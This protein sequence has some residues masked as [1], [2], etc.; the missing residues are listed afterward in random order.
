[1]ASKIKTVKVVLKKMRKV[2]GNKYKAQAEKLQRL[3]EEA[4]QQNKILRALKTQEFIPGFSF[5]PIL[6]T[7]SYKLCHAFAYPD[8]VEGMF[9][10]IEARTG[11]LD[12]IV[13][14]GAQMWVM[15]HLTVQI[16]PAMIDEAEEFAKLHGEPFNR[17][18]WE[19]IIEKYD[20]FLPIKIRITPEGMPIR[21][22][23]AIVTV[24]CTDKKVQWLT[25]YI[26][27]ALLRGIWYPTTIASLDYSIKHHLRE[28]YE[29]TGAD[30]AMLSFSLHDFG[31]RGVTCGE[32]AQIGGAAHLVNFMGSDTIE[33]IRA[34]NFFYHEKMSGFSVP[35]TEHSV[36]CSFGDGPGEIEYV[37]HVLKNLAKPGGIV[38]I[39]IDA[40]DCYRLVEIICTELKQ[41][42][43]DCKAKVVLRPDSGDMH[44]TVPRIIRMLDLA[45]GHVVN[46]AGFK[47]LNYVGILQGDGVDHLAIK[48]LLGHLMA[49]GYAA[50]NIVFGSGGALLQK[51]N[52]DTYKF[53]Q[54]TS[55]ILVN[56]KWVGIRKD[57]VTDK[58]KRSKKGRLTTT[59]SLMTGEVM[60]MGL[61][62]G[63]LNSEYVDVMFTLYDC[64]VITNTTTLAEVRART[65]AGTRA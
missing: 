37:R 20:G 10:Y 30:M 60:T 39:V 29:D 47:K 1:M 49:M 35:A 18:G 34:A 31:G 3:L 40:Y 16:I 44:E 15:K 11:G 26:E 23:N 62:D 58:G 45:F 38:S 5:N 41:E 61:D 21:S 19:H 55:A 51:V 52:R 7:D 8:T 57:P 65:T 2:P 33:G 13:P 27:T 59:R 14:F 56:G 42:I 48:S 6:A 4:Q 46:K 32:Q 64:G 12:I 54:K 43:I 53:A 50:D 24:E 22:G 17:A 28:I 63:P 36:E 25:S 9:A